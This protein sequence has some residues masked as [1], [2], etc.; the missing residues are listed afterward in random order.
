VHIAALRF[1]SISCLGYCVF[2][3]Y[4]AHAGTAIS[5]GRTYTATWSFI[6]NIV[7]EI[8]AIADRSWIE[9]THKTPAG[10]TLRQLEDQMRA[11]AVGPAAAA[12]AGKSAGG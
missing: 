6:A 3:G 8:Y 1:P 11:I 12:A 10:L 9:K 7:D 5:W 4:D 2:S